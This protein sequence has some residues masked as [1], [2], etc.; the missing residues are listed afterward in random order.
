MKIKQ[1]LYKE[2]TKRHEEEMSNEYEVESEIELKEFL[3][4]LVQEGLRFGA[5]NICTDWALLGLLGQARSCSRC[6]TQ[7]SCSPRRF[8]ERAKCTRLVSRAKDGHRAM[9]MTR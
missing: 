5:G 2:I 6:L 8:A 9:G 3:V 4:Q 7:H 1:S